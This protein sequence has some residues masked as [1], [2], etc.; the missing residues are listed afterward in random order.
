MRKVIARGTLALWLM[1]PSLANSDC[2]QGLVLALDVSGS[3]DQGEYRQQMIGISTALKDPVVVSLILSLP[4]APISISAF[5]WSGASYQN[6]FL[7]WTTLDTAAAI[8]HVA[9]AI[10]THPRRRAPF[11]TAIGQSILFASALVSNAPACWRYTI[12]VSS[13]GKNN[14]GPQPREVRDSLALKDITVILGVF[15]H[16][17]FALTD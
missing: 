16:P 2:R 3:I 5:G 12:D 10:A 14:D 17:T 8:D 7:D 1:F 11:T 6:L 4:N 9:E 13:D 15:E